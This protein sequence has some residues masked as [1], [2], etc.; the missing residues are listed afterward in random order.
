MK[1]LISGASSADELP[2]FDPSAIDA[3]VC[4][5]PERSDL[6]RELPGTEVLLG[7]NFRGGDLEACWSQVDALRWINWCGAGVDATLFSGLVESDVELTNARGIF[8]TAMAEDV[9]GYML[10][11]VKHVPLTMQ[12]QREGEWKYRLTR[13]LT[14]QRAA[15]YGVGSIG[16]EVAR[17]LDALGVETVGIGRSERDDTQFGRI[18]ANSDA[19]AIAGEVDWVV[20]VM[21]STA[22]TQ[23]FFDASFFAAMQPHAHFINIG[24]GSAQ[25][26]VALQTALREGQIAGAMLDVFKQEPLPQDSALWNTPNLFVSPHISGDYAGFESDMVRLFLDNLGRYLNGEPLRNVIDKQLGFV[27]S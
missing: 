17:V 10:H 11:I 18:R 23:N 9:L 7:W 25:D 3:D 6:Q 2:G 27:R 15:I 5:A 4:F 12:S 21:P 22:A 24:R 14:G 13:R 16:R 1:L 8:D 20:G 19:L 26:E